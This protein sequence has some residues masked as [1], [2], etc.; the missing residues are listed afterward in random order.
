MQNRRHLTDNLINAAAPRERRFLQ[1]TLDGRNAYSEAQT[2][3]WLQSKTRIC[4]D[5][6]HLYF[7]SWI[8]LQAVGV[9]RFDTQ[10][11]FFIRWWLYLLPDMT[12]IRFDVVL[13]ETCMVSIRSCVQHVLKIIASI[14]T[15]RVKNH[16]RHT[17]RFLSLNML[18]VWCVMS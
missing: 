14:P 4:S 10:R 18:T 6:L 7:L 12:G 17:L 13:I 9:F 8:Q 1:T 16:H 2:T 11:G 5:V 15:T 3:T